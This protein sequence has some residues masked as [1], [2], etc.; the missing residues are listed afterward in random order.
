MLFQLIILKSY[1][2]DLFL[3][4]PLSTSYSPNFIELKS[5]NLMLD[6]FAN[7]KSEFWIMFGL[8]NELIKAIKASR[9]KLNW[10]DLEQSSKQQ[11]QQPLPHPSLVARSRDASDLSKNNQFTRVKLYRTAHTHTHT[12]TRL[13]NHC[14]VHMGF[15]YL[16][17]LGNITIL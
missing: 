8:S 14:S 17:I 7:R 16:D 11:Q 3:A 13:R 4:T 6:L 2:K 1:L 15:T 10:L 9:W 12:R 5:I